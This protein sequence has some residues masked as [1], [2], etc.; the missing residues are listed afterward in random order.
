MNMEEPH[1][2]VTIPSGYKYPMCIWKSQR[3]HLCI[4][5]SFASMINQFRPQL[6]S[7]SCRL[8]STISTSPILDNPLQPSPSIRVSAPIPE[9][10]SMEI[11]HSHAELIC[12]YDGVSRVNISF[13]VGFS[14]GSASAC[15]SL[16]LF[17]NSRLIQTSRSS[18]SV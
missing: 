16:C 4:G 2:H 14:F 3:S 13:S 17:I 11:S 18:V 1:S 6:T 10:C 5:Q 7:R 9:S 12:A 8:E 15:S